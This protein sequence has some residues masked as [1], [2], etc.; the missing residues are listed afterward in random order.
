MTR[1]LGNFNKFKFRIFDNI[2]CYIYWLYINKS[3]S[4]TLNETIE[5]KNR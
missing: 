4:A 1:S 2:G 3:T 5:L